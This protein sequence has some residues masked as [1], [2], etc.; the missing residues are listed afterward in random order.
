M[1]FGQ[2]K[3]NDFHGIRERS[4]LLYISTRFIVISNCFQL[5]NSLKFD[6]YYLTTNK[7]NVSYSIDAF[8]KDLHG[9]NKRHKSLMQ[10]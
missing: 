9:F 1:T 5:N 10:N 2:L 8:A 4:T 7:Q 6:P 3:V